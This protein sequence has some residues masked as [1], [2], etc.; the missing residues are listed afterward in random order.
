MR[1]EAV[2]HGIKD[3]IVDINWSE[4]GEYC[5]EMQ[6]KDKNQLFVRY[7]KT[8][9]AVAEYLVSKSILLGRVI[10]VKE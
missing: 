3:M 1:Y 2:R 8:E 5:I 10:E 7:A 6:Y 9:K 4:V